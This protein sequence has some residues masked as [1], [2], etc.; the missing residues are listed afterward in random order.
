MSPSGLRVLLLGAYPN[1][2]LQIVGGVEAV[3][4]ALVPALAAH[5]AVA[6]VTVGVLRRRGQLRRHQIS[7]TLDRIDIPVPF[8]SG[9][10]LVHSAQCVQAVRRLLPSLRPDL[11]HGTGIDR[12]GDVATQLGLPAVVTI[13]GLVHIEARQSARGLSGMIKTLLFEMMVRR[14]LHRA[15]VAISISR[16]DASL[17]APMIGGRQVRIANPIGPEFFAAAPAPPLCPQVLFAGVIRPRKNVLGIVNAFAR[18]RQAIPTARLVLA[19]P[20][21]EPDYAQAVRQRASQLGISDAVVWA[22][23]LAPAGVL[24][25]LHQSHVLTL[26]SDQETLPTIIAQALAVGRPVVSSR[27]GG[28]AEMVVD[29]ETGYLV[30][31]GDEESL[32]DRLIA[33]L[34]D[35]SSAQA[36][37]VRAAAVAR[38][39]YDPASVADQ[40]VGAYRLAMG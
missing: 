4:Y 35:Q 26:F 11:V 39:S 40:T 28:T 13:H 9:D 8:L 14:V 24:A 22:G 3:N 32:A 20:E 18:V 30:A 31:P 33:V 37:G 36:M 25:A 17:L 23:H 1:D 16:Y 34:Q 2:L 21:L 29:G 5:P 12:V 6:H 10:V 19:G 38:Q 15:Q 7:A 27:V